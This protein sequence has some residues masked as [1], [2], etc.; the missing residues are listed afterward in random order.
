M[1]RILSILLVFLLLLSCSASAATYSNDPDA[2]N[3]SAQ[4]V[5]LLAV[6]DVSN[7]LISTGSGFV[8]FSDEYVVTNY[9]VIEGGDAVKIMLLS[10]GATYDAQLVG[11]DESLDIAVLKIDAEGLTAAQFGDS[12]LLEIGDAAYAKRLEAAYAV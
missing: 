2:I 7:R 9:H 4:S 3:E 11:Y 12:D 10:D 8:A 6:Y 1:K 5:V